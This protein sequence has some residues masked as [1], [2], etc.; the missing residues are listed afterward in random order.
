MEKV[1]EIPL[2]HYQSVSSSNEY[3]PVCNKKMININLNVMIWKEF[4]GYQIFFVIFIKHDYYFSGSW[5][6]VLIVIN[7]ELHWF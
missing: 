4:L 2:P 1:K 3:A 5:T 7:T 6:Q